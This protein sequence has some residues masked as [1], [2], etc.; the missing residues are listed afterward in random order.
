M[1]ASGGV[2][3][4]QEE[5]K[6]LL[7]L[8]KHL[9]DSIPIGNAHNF[10][11]YAPDGKD[12]DEK[13]CIKSVVSHAL[14]S[15]FGSRRTPAGEDV[16]ITFKSRGPALEE[17]V[18]VLRDFITGNGGANVLLTQWVDDLRRAARAAIEGAGK[19]VIILILHA[20]ASPKFM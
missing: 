18:T 1:S 12:V 9:P 17:V 11:S 20:S 16:I 4:Y 2:S 13:G 10:E 19:R 7:R 14:G 6:D 15:S 8:L 3:H 5:L